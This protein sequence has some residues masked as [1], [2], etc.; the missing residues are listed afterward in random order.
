MMASKEEV[1][2]LDKKLKACVKYMILNPNSMIPQAMRAIF[3]TIKESQNPKYQMKVRR[4]LQL[5]QDKQVHKQVPAVVSTN[6]SAGVSSLSTPPSNSPSSAE[7][8]P[9][10]APAEELSPPK[11]IRR[12]SK[13]ALSH[14]LNQT[15]IRSK[16]NAAHKKATTIYQ[17]ECSK[18]D[19]TGLSARRVCEIVNAEHNTSVSHRSVQKFV[20][21][22][23]AGE[24]PRRR[25]PNPANLSAESFSLLLKAFES[26]I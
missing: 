24:S 3:F 6:G 21:D 14:K 10:P 25:G 11:K 26:H 18:T 7:S 23:R 22:G 19:G 1:K 16:E 15:K 13:Q 9:T 17:A 20:K 4:L 8:T 12:S 2:N 5:T